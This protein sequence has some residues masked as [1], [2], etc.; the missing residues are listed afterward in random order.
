[1]A[2][3]EDDSM[4]CEK[5]TSSSMNL[6]VSYLYLWSSC[7]KLSTTGHGPWTTL[8]SIV[9]STFSAFSEAA[10]RG[11]GRR[12]FGVVALLVASIFS[13]TSGLRATDPRCTVA[14]EEIF[15][16]RWI[17]PFAL[18]LFHRVVS[19]ASDYPILLPKN[20]N[21]HHGSFRSNP[22]NGEF[23]SPRGPRKGQ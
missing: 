1:M 23:H 14:A 5:S 21:N 2:V 10:E 12:G 3:V 18:L 11:L 16:H 13:L 17:G 20:N 15:H 8:L 9:V 22:P 19:S 4:V 6:T 7:V